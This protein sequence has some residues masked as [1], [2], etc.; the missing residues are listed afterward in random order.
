MDKTV[1][2]IGAG[3][4]GLAAARRLRAAGIEPFVFEK[5]RGLGGRMATR[6]VGEHSFDH[7][8]QF[9]TVKSAAFGDL[10]ASWTAAGSAAPWGGVNVGVPGMSTPA[11]TMGSD[12]NIEQGRQITALSRSGTGW[13]LHE[14]SGPTSHALNGRFDA[15]ILAIPAPQARPLAVSAGV[16]FAALDGVVMAPC[17]AML[18]VVDRPLSIATDYLKPDTGPIAWI[19]RNDSKPGRPSG[20]AS[21][22]VHATPSWT[23]E[24]LEVTNDAAAGLLL[25]ALQDLLDIELAPSL[26]ITHRWRF[27]LVETAA[28][29][30]CLWDE[31]QRL[32]ACGDWCI[33]ARIEDAFS[34]GEAMAARVVA[35]LGGGNGS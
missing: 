26:V 15:V 5:S 13:T 22:V 12:L 34:S 18:L 32:G 2:I 16:E 4:A 31:Q 1:A 23:R 35:T 3:L 10:M 20:S 27:A 30:D 19:A 21:Y 6:R 24:N 8:A 29:Q 7:G 9:F 11:K 28:G 25:G 33:G 14:A 17:W